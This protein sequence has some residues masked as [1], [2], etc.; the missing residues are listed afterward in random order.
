MDGKDQTFVLFQKWPCKKENVTR[1]ETSYRLPG[2]IYDFA[3][4]IRDDIK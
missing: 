1:L 3:L 2:K 4:S